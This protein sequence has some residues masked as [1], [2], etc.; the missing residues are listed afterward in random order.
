MAMQMNGYVYKLESAEHW[1]EADNE[2]WA[3]VCATETVKAELGSAMIDGVR[4]PVYE[5]VDGAI[6]ACSQVAIRDLPA[7]PCPI[8]G[9]DRS[10]ASQHGCHHELAH[11]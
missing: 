11:R 2:D 4:T 1:K 7:D 5:G 8:C 9:E 6:Y 3:V 10:H